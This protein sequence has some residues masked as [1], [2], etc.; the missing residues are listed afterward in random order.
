MN[1]APRYFFPDEEPE[2]DHPYV[3]WDVYRTLVGDLCAYCGQHGHRR[4][5]CPNRPL[6]EIGTGR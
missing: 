2:S 3:P 5:G 1:T 4:I 6:S